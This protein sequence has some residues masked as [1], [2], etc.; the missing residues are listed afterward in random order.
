[1]D[2][3]IIDKTDGYPKYMQLLCDDVDKNEWKCEYIK[4]RDG[5]KICYY[6]DMIEII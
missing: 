1:M 5:R 6:P 2:D 4:I 3:A